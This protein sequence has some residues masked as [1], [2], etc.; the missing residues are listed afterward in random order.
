MAVGVI[1]ITMAIYFMLKPATPTLEDLNKRYV[2]ANTDEQREYIIS[3]VVDYYA[4]MAV[5][6]SIIRVVDSQIQ[7][8]IDTTSLDSVYLSNRFVSKE[9]EISSQILFNVFKEDLLTFAVIAKLKDNEYTWQNLMAEGI[10]VAETLDRR[11]NS[12]WKDYLVRLHTFSKK[13]L[14]K[15]LVCIQAYKSFYRHQSDLDQ[16]FVAEGYGCIA[17]R[18]SLELGLEALTAEILAIFQ[19]TTLFHHGCNEISIAIGDQVMLTT[20][21]PSRYLRQVVQFYQAQAYFKN[22]LVTHA[23][24]AFTKVRDSA[25]SLK[26]TAGNWFRV[27]SRLQIASSL[28]QLARYQ[29]SLEVCNEVEQFEL[30]GVE[31]SIL[32]NARGLACKRLSNYARADSEYVVAIELAKKHK[33]II[34]LTQY[35]QN[36][37][38]LYS[39]LREYQRALEIFLEVKLLI[40]EYLPDN[41]E[42][43]VSV[44]LDIA[45][46]YSILEKP[47]LATDALG[48][49]KTSLAELGNRPWRKAMLYAALADAHREQGDIESALANF[50]M[51][52][53][54]ARESG[55]VRKSLEYQI[56]MSGCLLSV[57]RADDALETVTQALQLS[58]SLNAVEHTLDAQAFTAEA[59]Y[60]TGDLEKAISISDSMT[61]TIKKIDSSLFAKGILMA[62][63]NRIYEHLKR[64]AFYEIQAGRYDIAFEKLDFAKAEALKYELYLNAASKSLAVSDKDLRNWLDENT[65]VVD[66]FVSRDS[67]YVFV[68]TSDRLELCRRPLMGEFL[69]GQVETFSASIQTYAHHINGSNLQNHSEYQRTRS[70]GRSLGTDLLFWRD[71]SHQHIR[72]IFIV[73]DEGLYDLPFQALVVSD[74]VEETFLSER[75]AIGYTPS[76]T[77]LGAIFRPPGARSPVVDGRILVS[78]D[79]H[80]PDVSDLLAFLQTQFPIVDELVADTWPPKQREILGEIEKKYDIYLFVGHGIN[81]PLAESSTINLFVKHKYSNRSIVLPFTIQDFGS[82]GWHGIE[83]VMLV[84][85]ETLGGKTIRGTGQVGF[86]DAFIGWGVKNVLSG[87]WR[88]DATESIHQIRDLFQVLSGKNGYLAALR[89]AEIKAIARLKTKTSLWRNPVPYL[90]S[91]LVLFSALQSA[92]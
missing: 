67:L 85:C 74:S 60:L 61:A 14:L 54:M 22:G 55:L 26:G 6:D 59:Y 29:E 35:K 16:S 90:W 62:Y 13:N 20:K 12:G 53:R 18:N 47:G 42:R 65:A 84:G 87:R 78:A 91:S 39:D 34:N 72:N 4:S 40:D 41:Y 24:K 11:D 57:G 52:E 79:P 38:F 48:K 56:A 89:V 64:F 28:W 37:G 15:W 76:A 23:L 80:I 43:K 68:M 32:H 69:L 8:M 83:T 19:Y 50:Q 82:V 63:R 51:A 46:I 71:K 77:L 7:M 31:R 92:D 2:F 21:N 49:A 33:D 45:R 81:D 10:T 3:Q 73:P 17:L 70:L 44:L 5:P 86:H 30:N 36:R 75:V 25:D 88:I 66:Y 9:G 58:R 1:V 27:Q